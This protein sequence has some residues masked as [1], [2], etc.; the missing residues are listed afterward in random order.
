[1]SDMDKQ[2]SDLDAFFAAAKTE[3]PRVSDDLMARVMADAMA[4]MPRAAEPAAEVVPPAP[5]RTSGWLSGVLDVI[6]GWPA[7][8]GLLTAGLVGVWIG[9]SPPVPLQEL[10][11]AFLGGVLVASNDVSEWPSLADAFGEDF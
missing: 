8:G 10:D 3:A 11:V 4:E 1:M 7:A 2:D 6:G 5:A 9:V